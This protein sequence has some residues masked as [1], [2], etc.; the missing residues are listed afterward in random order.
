M[1]GGPKVHL[2]VIIINPNVRNTKTRNATTNP[3][4]RCTTPRNM[5]K[6]KNS[7]EICAHTKIEREPANKHQHV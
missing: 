5:N 3:D 2:R 1:I 4:A 6:S 7:D